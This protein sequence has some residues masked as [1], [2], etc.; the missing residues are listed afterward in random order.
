MSY[1]GPAARPFDPEDVDRRFEFRIG[2]CVGLIDGKPG[3]RWTV[4]GRLFPDVPMLHVQEGD[5]VRMTV[6]NDSG[7]VHPI[8][9]HG[10]HAVAFSRDGEAATGNPWWVDSLN[11]ADGQTYEI[12]FVATPRHLDDHRHKSRPRTDGLV[13]HLAYAGVTEPYPVGGPADNGPE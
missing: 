3:F 1:G 11:V 8:Q 7:R 10:H 12:A 4:T 13:A 2:R 6:S 9:L 5:I